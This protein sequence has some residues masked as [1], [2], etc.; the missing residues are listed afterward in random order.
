MI[1]LLIWLHFIGDFVFQNDKMAQN[2]STSNKWLG[3]HC[4]AYM[5]PFLL[6]SWEFAILNCLTNT[7]TF[8]SRSL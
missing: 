5:I 8:G 6:I 2:K 4:L 3:I 7:V 1:Y